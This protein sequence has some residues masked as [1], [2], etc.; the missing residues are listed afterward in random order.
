MVLV[1]I[2]RRRPLGDRA[3]VL[4]ILYPNSQH[5]TTQILAK[6]KHDA[7]AS[8]SNWETGHTRLRIVLVFIAEVDAL[9]I[10]R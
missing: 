4:V 7:Q 10:T 2:E 3:I 6:Y 8:V 9:L 5:R 1:V